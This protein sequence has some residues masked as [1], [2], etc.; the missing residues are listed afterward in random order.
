MKKLTLLLLMGLMTSQIWAQLP[1]PTTSPGP[2]SYGYTWKTDSDPAGPAFDWVEII[3]NNL[4]TKVN[5][6]GDDNVIGKIPMGIQFQFYWTGKTELCIGSNGFLSLN[7]GNC[8]NISSSATGFPPTPT[9]SS[10][11]DVIA[12]YMS[13]LSFSGLGNP[14]EVYYYSDATNNRFVVTYSAVPYWV[15]ATIDPNQW[16]GSNTFQVILDAS[17]STVTFQ[18]QSMVGNWSSGYDDA[19]YPFV[20]GIENISGTVGMLAPSLPMSAASKPGPNSRITFSPPVTPLLAITDLDVS[21]VQNQDRA[22]FFI[23]WPQ[24]GATNNYPLRGLVSN[25]GN[26]DVSGDIYTLA[27]IT[28]TLN[29]QLYIAFDT[30]FGGLDQGMAAEVQYDL[31]FNPPTPGPYTYSIL[32]TNPT[33]LGDINGTNNARSAELVAVD[34]TGT[35]ANL[36]FVSSNFVKLLSP[37]E[38]NLGLVNWS[39]NNDDSGAGIYFDPFAYPVTITAV[40]FFLSSL[41]NCTPTEGMIA[42]IFE[43]DPAT[44]LPGTQRYQQ[45]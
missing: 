4:G 42:Q 40:E 6:L 9:N 36:D 19:D 14:G 5:G 33:T 21:S 11:N 31:Q 22:G 30:I 8:V 7:D 43:Y 20:A 32:I 16:S 15:D 12:P 38:T 41:N 29:N 25:A 10:P 23:P 2:D 17:D 3:T 27:Q 13:D 39:S 37:N 35:E 1:W 28:D 45:K 24:G 18:Y 26:T 34:T 44:N